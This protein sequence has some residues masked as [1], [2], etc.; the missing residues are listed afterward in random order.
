MLFDLS[1]LFLLIGLVVWA[2]L[3]WRKRCAV[4]RRRKRWSRSSTDPY[5]PLP[6]IGHLHHFLGQPKYRYMQW[7]LRRAEHEGAGKTFE[8]FLPGLG[9]CVFITDPQYVRHK[10]K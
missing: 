6:I 2:A 1:A 9:R 8:V 3:S 5:A 7:Y 10:Y 4:S